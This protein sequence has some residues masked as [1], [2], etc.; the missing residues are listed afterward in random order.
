[1]C[2]GMRP[3]NRMNPE[4]HIQ[5]TLRQRIVQ[6]PHLVLRLRDGHSIARHDNNFIRRGK[7]CRRFFRAG[8]V[9][10]ARFLARGPCRLLLPERTEKHV[11]KRAVHGLGHVHGKNKTGRTIQRSGDDQQFV[12]Q[13]KA[14]RRRRKPRLGI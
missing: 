3:S 14:H 7:Y 9:Y 2:P 4:S 6:F 10:R 5:T 11:G 1:M 13:H 8:A 12:V